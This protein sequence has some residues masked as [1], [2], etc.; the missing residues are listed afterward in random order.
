M[1]PWWRNIGNKWSIHPPFPP[2][3]THTHPSPRGGGT[4][5]TWEWKGTKDMPLLSHSFVNYIKLANQVPTVSSSII[6][7]SLSGNIPGIDPRSFRK[8]EKANVNM[9]LD[10]M[11]HVSEED[12]WGGLDGDTEWT[13]RRWGGGEGG[14]HVTV[15]NSIFLTK[16]AK[17]KSIPYVF[18]LE[19][20]EYGTLWGSTLPPPPPPPPP[21]LEHSLKFWNMPLKF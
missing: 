5:W 20:L 1:I 4:F 7:Y 14:Q 3:P 12:D 17:S 16:M 9:I 21:P 2:P 18:R 6:L 10:S 13:E 8:V 11:M 15:K 19:M